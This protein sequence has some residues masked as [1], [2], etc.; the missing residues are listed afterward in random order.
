MYT[1][2]FKK[3]MKDYIGTRNTREHKQQQTLGSLR[4]LFDI[5]TLLLLLLL[6]DNHYDP[7]VSVCMFVYQKVTSLSFVT[8]RCK[9]VSCIYK[10][11]FPCP[12]IHLTPSASVRVNP[13]YVWPPSNLLLPFLTSFLSVFSLQRPAPLRQSACRITDVD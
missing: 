7:V 9:F 10:L 5:T 11:F 6:T 13:L 1:I 8:E 4:R 2:W 12:S 3:L